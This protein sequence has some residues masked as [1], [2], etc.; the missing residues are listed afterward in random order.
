MKKGQ[1]ILELLKKDGKISILDKHSSRIQAKHILTLA[2]LIGLFLIVINTAIASNNYIPEYS[3]KDG[4][5]LQWDLFILF[6]K[7]LVGYIFA[8]AVMATA[9]YGIY[10]FLRMFHT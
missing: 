4:I 6:G 3:K 8:I 1:T 7:E 10:R 2:A 5:K 9:V